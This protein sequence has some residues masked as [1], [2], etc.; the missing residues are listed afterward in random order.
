VNRGFFRC[1]IKQNLH[2]IGCLV[3]TE[4]SDCL[5]VDEEV[6][7][8]LLVVVALLTVVVLVAVVLVA[9]VLV[10]VVLVAVVLVAVS[11]LVVPHLQLQ[12]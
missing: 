12:R 1:D 3:I 8:A 4:G 5:P 11:W 10:A 9:V 2:I 6:E 7:V